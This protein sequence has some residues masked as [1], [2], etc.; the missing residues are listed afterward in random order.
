MAAYTFLKNPP[1]ALKFPET[2]FRMY[3][4]ASRGDSLYAPAHTS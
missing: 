4:A 3:D 1:R 2:R